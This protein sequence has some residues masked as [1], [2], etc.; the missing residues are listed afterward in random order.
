MSRCIGEV[1]LLGGSSPQGWKDNPEES[2][3]RELE[4]PRGLEGNDWLRTGGGSSEEAQG[5]KR[6]SSFLVDG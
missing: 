2:A 6:G 5:R 3:E 1:D 4:L